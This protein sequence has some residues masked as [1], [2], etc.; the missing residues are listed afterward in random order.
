LKNKKTNGDKWFFLNGPVNF[1]GKR[2]I[3]ADLPGLKRFF[4]RAARQNCPPPLALFNM[5]R[6]KN[7]PWLLGQP[8]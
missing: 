5:D 2:A 7:W 4:R 1:N 6:K 8:A 3:V